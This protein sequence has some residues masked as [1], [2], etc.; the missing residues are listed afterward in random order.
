MIF[1]LYFSIA[2]VRVGFQQEMYSVG[3][4]DGSVTVCVE[5]SAVDLPIEL[6]FN[7]SA[8]IDGS[9]AFSGIHLITTL[10]TAIGSSVKLPSAD[11]NLATCFAEHIWHQVAKVH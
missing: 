8:T 2:E 4:S 7:L 1:N 11:L 9:I 6:S 10:L 5:V 3:E